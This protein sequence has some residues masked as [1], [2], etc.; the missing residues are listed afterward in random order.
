MMGSAYRA[1]I[2]EADVRRLFSGALVAAG[3]LLAGGCASHPV[4]LG[5]QVRTSPCAREQAAAGVS[6]YDVSWD[7]SAADYPVTYR[8]RRP[9]LSTS[10]SAPVTAAGEKP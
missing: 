10:Q 9:A 6:C 7:R 5:E 2:Q 4:A 8:I 3:L 1:A